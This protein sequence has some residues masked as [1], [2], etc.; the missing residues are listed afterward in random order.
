MV[1]VIVFG[2]GVALRERGLAENL[3]KSEWSG[4]RPVGNIIRP[5]SDGTKNGRAYLLFMKRM[6]FSK[7]IRSERMKYGKI[8]P[9]DCHIPQRCRPQPERLLHFLGG[10]GLISCA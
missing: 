2:V 10:V 3:A 8:G 9:V 5:Q 6:S 1:G 4:K 7:S